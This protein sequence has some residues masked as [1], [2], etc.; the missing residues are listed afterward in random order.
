[1]Q[2]KYINVNNLK[3]SEKLLNFVNDELLKDTEI[4]PDSFWEGFDKV[5]HELA[6]KN[7]ELLDIRDQLQKKI[8]E[9]HIKI[10]E[11]KLI[12]MNIKNFF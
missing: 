11:M 2:E 10:R 5:V 4:S 7:K 3:V 1:M 9:W 6:P 12:L 8:D